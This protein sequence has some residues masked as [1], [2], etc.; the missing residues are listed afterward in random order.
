[1]PTALHNG[2]SRIKQNQQ[3]YTHP[4]N[5]V[6]LAMWIIALSSHAILIP[7]FIRE[8]LLHSKGRSTKLVG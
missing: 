5:I 6:T 8:V 4:Y 2:T 7:L 1:M 3:T